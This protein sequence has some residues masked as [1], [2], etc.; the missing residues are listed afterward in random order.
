MNSNIKINSSEWCD[1]LFEKKNKDYGAYVLRQSASKRYAYAFA[2]TMALMVFVAALPNLIGA[3]KNSMVSEVYTNTEDHKLTEIRLE[4]QVKKE[5][6]IKQVAAPPPPPLRASIKFTPPVITKDEDI[7]EAEV[8][9]SVDDL[10]GTKISISVADVNGD[11]KKGILIEELDKNKL[12]IE[13]PKKDTGPTF[14]AEVMPAFLGGDSEMYKFISDNLK[15]PVVAQETGLQGKVTI[16]FVVTKTGKVS[17]VT[18]LRGFDPSCDNEAKRVV[19]IMPNWVP[20]K[21]NGVPVAVYYTL[22]IVFKLR[23]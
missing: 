19:S 5:D 17:D 22:P 18:I 23:H 15:Y 20:G 6:L 14:V 10:L 2:I 13:A 12:I 7:K 16:R 4:E 8:M 11:V 21:Q 1:M 3:V 9:K